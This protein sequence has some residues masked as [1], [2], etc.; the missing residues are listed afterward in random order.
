M[1]AGVELKDLSVWNL[2]R[3]KKLADGPPADI[4]GDSEVLLRRLVELFKHLKKGNERFAAEIKHLLQLAKKCQKASAE[5]DAI[6]G[7]PDPLELRDKI[8][9]VK[10]EL[11]VI[12]KS[13]FPLELRNK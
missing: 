7:N 5:I 11:E 3:L 12:R 10:T 9:A 4:R 8:Q 13:S 1:A 2:K 6:M